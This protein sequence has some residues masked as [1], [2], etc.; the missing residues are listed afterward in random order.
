MIAMLQRLSRRHTS[1]VQQAK[2]G[3]PFL[4]GDPQYT[5]RMGTPGTPFYRENGDPGS[6]FSRDPQNFMTPADQEMTV[7][8]SLLCLLVVYVTSEKVKDDYST[9]IFVHPSKGNDSQECVSSSTSENTP[10]RTLGY[11]MEHLQNK[12]QVI[13]LSSSDNYSV[14][15]GVL[16]VE[17]KALFSLAG[18]QVAT[19]VCTNNSGFAFSNILELYLANLHVTGCGA[20]Q[21]ST[22]KNY[23]EGATTTAYF[24][25]AVYVNSCAKVS[26]NDV[27]ITESEGTAVTMYNSGSQ[28]VS[29]VRSLFTDNKWNSTYAPTFY[30][31]GFY[32]A[33][34]RR[35]LT[36]NQESLAL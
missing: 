21:R 36:V 9:V 8:I 24:L 4:R 1:A 33:E 11:T 31:G 26:I 28:E 35:L 29:V 23:T 5:G 19:V 15:S 18:E 22:S 34:T 32:I 6:P 12:T 17:G 7:T 25:V 20:L 2:E 10:C 30:G 27:T 13:L 3:S 14:N 16:K